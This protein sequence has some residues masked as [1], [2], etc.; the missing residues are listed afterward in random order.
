MG[1]WEEKI[2]EGSYDGVR[3][4]F[5]RTTHDHENELDVQSFN[6]R[7]GGPVK[8]RGRRHLRFDILAIVIEDDYPDV[9]I[10]LLEKVDAGQP[11]EFVDP[12]FGSFKAVVERAQV[13]H[14]ADDAANAATIQLTVI[15]HTDE[16]AQPAKKSA[17][18]K[19]NETRGRAAEV[20]VASE[21]YSDAVLVQLEEAASLAVALASQ[22]YVAAR[23]IAD[24]ADD[25]ATT[26]AACADVLEAD[27][28]ILS[29]VAIQAQINGS[30][31]GIDAVL[32]QIADYTFAE[33]EELAAALL[34]TAAALRET[35]AIILN[36]KPPIVERTVEADICLL[37]LVHAIHGDS[38][39]VD[40]LLTL[41]SF[42][43]PLLVLAGTKV[44][45]YA[46]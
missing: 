20:H 29:S 42:A 11:K 36:T 19:A 31:S 2:Q 3:F 41:N 32:V 38:S 10:N 9:M 22:S 45:H 6:N 44:R 17:P 30:L 4:D 24:E 23:Q 18:A 21:D 5:V 34:A 40:E 16:D 8:F 46:F 39:R 28:D 15:E 37:A 27:G 43:D 26:A 13:Q 33:A 14:D 25:A 12:I 35:G 7:N 1:F